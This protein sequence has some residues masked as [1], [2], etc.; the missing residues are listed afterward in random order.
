MLVL[1]ALGAIEAGARI[2]HRRQLVGQRRDHA[3]ALGEGLDVVDHL[4]GVVGGDIHAQL[5]AELADLILFGQF[6]SHVVLLR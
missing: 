2:F 5:G 4:L 6:E 3:I 1:V